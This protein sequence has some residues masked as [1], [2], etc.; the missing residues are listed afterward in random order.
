MAQ[1]ILRRGSISSPLRTFAWFMLNTSLD[2]IYNIVLGLARGSYDLEKIYKMAAKAQNDEKQRKQLYKYIAELASRSPVFSVSPSSGIPSQA[3]L[4]GAGGY[5]ANDVMS[6][7]GEAAYLSSFADALKVYQTFSDPKYTWKDGV[8]ELY[9]KFGGALPA[10]MGGPLVRA[11][12]SWAYS[13]ALGGSSK[14]EMNELQYQLEMERIE[15]PGEVMM[16]NFIRET[17]PIEQQQ[18]QAP[19]RNTKE[20]ENIMKQQFMD[21]YGKRLEQ[22]QPKKPKEIKE[23]TPPTEIT[24]KVNIGKEATTP[25]KAPEGLV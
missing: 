2:I 7:V 15:D 3:I 19:K 16:E 9:R 20:Q 14:G 5:M 10:G 12:T 13:N 17:L 11:A 24:T 18:R 25:E 4:A 8:F 1:Q 6:A 22:Y 23:P 21:L